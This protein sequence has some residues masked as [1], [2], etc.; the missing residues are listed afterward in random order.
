MS[1][2]KLDTTQLF[3]G[4][5]ASAALLGAIIAYATSSDQPQSKEDADRKPS[6]NE[7]D[8]DQLMTPLSKAKTPRDREGKKVGKEVLLHRKKTNVRL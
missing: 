1:L 7:D 2:S 5:A 6:L 3:M 8:Q 4:A